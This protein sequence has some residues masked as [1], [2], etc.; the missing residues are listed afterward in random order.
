ME[1]Y[2]YI[3]SVSNVKYVKLTVSE[4]EWLKFIM[5]YEAEN[6]PYS[7]YDLCKRLNEYNRRDGDKETAYKVA[8]QRTAK[9]L[10]L[11]LLR[12]VKGNYRRGAIKY[13]LS[14]D[15][16]FNIFLNNLFRWPDEEIQDLK[17][18]EKFYED[19]I[20]FKTF[21]YPNF[22]IETIRAVH[23][24]PEIA[25]TFVDFLTSCCDHTLELCK[26]KKAYFPSC[27]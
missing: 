23:N 9:L 11:K 19:N 13:R 26:R 21:L 16:W 18:I 20:L 2:E 25:F 12:L 17:I 6:Y 15:G 24:S 7:A 10:D 8:H 5:I 4:A 3:S 22:D 14:I 27:N 1:Y